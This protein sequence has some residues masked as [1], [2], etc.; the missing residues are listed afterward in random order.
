MTFVTMKEILVLSE[1][2]EERSRENAGTP[3]TADI[4]LTIARDESRRRKTEFFVVD[5]RGN[6]G[7]ICAVSGRNR[8]IGLSP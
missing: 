2:P 7:G 8:E 4:L 5:L 3:S 6:K 1:L